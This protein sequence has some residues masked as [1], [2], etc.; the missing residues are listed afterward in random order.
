[1]AEEDLFGAARKEPA[2]GRNRIPLRTMRENTMLGGMR[3]ERDKNGRAFG[4]G[5]SRV[6]VGNGKRDRGGERA[7][8]LASST[9]RK[10]PAAEKR[11]TTSYRQRGVL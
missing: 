6:Q 10:S 1:M 11:E 4:G 3:I 7:D 2:G 9:E 5:G 8:R